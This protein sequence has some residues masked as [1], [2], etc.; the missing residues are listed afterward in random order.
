MSIDPKP[1]KWAT[2]RLLVAFTDVLA[3]VSIPVERSNIDWPACFLISFVCSLAV[4]VWLLAIRFQQGIDWSEP[5]SLT[6]PFWPLRQYPL[7]Y[8]FVCSWALVLMGSAGMT[9]SIILRRGH[10]AVSGTFLFIGIFMAVPLTLFAKKF[11]EER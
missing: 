4:C 10:E 1:T 6:E 2:A 5:Y 8:L 9:S 11:S 3:G 7:R